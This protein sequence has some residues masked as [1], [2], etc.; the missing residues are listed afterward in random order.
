VRA[1]PARRIDLDNNATTALAP[2]AREAMLPFLAERAANPSAITS[3]GRAAREALEEARRAIAQLIHVSARRIVFTSGGSEADNLALKGVMRAA[4]AKG[5]H[6]I[7]S[8]IEH[9]AV[10]ETC[11]ALQADGCR[12]TL[13]PVDRFGLVDPAALAAALTPETVLVS[14]MMANNEIGTIEPV[15]ELSAVAHRAGA[16]FHTDAVQAAGRLAIDAEALGVDLLSLSAHQFHGPPGA[17]ALYVAKGVAIE[18]L[19]HGGKQ[20]GGLRGGT[21]NVAAIAGAGRAAQLAARGP[22]EAP[23]V[24]R[25]RDALDAGVRALVPGARLNGH[26]DERLANTLN[27]LLPGIRGESLVIAMDQQGVSLSSGSAC[28]SGSP[29][30]THVLLAIGRSAVEAHCSVRF[31]LSTHTTEDDVAGALEALARVLQEMEATVRFL[32]CK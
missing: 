4:R 9:P 31:S 12:V 20:E 25:L 14:V 32:P 1:R 24:R 10:L 21:E 29:D 18:P 11:R 7:T 6:L 2:E 22:E 3:A 16:L 27:L 23:R 19:I 13:L 15:A 8:A 5:R 30:P 17:G 26:P 28:K